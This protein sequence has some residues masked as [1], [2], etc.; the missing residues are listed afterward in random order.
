[1]YMVLA[2]AAVV[3]VAVVVA[4]VVVGFC[5]NEN[6]L[7]I[8]HVAMCISMLVVNSTFSFCLFFLTLVECDDLGLVGRVLVLVCSASLKSCDP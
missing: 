1:M 7:L 6:S 5:N 2:V 8:I 4:V 3:V